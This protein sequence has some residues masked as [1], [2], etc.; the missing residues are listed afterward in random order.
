[1]A[2]SLGGDHYSSKAVIPKEETPYRT[3]KCVR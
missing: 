3:N 2:E 1:M